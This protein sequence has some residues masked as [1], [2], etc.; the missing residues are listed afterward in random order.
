MPL[1]ISFVPVTVVAFG[2]A[3]LSAPTALMGKILTLTIFLFAR[4][5]GVS[6]KRELTVFAS[7]AL[8]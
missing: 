5:S 6:V 2:W 3:R 4:K 1:P 8:R 7:V